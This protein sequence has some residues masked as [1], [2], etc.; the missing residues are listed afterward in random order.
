M[1]VAGA[2]AAPSWRT[3]ASLPS[4]VPSLSVARR[5]DLIMERPARERFPARAPRRGTVA[6]SSGGAG[7]IGLA[8]RGTVCCIGV[9]HASG[10]QPS[11]LPQAA[12]GR[13]VR[14]LIRCVPRQD[15][16]AVRAPR[17]AHFAR[18]VACGFPRLQLGRA[19][20]GCAAKPGLLGVQ[21][22]ASR[23]PIARARLPGGHQGPS[24]AARASL[25]LGRDGTAIE[26]SGWDGRMTRFSRPGSRVLHERFPAGPRPG[27]PRRG[28][29]RASCAGVRPHRARTARLSEAYPRDG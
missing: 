6:T 2:S 26:L 8:P 4:R 9:G 11:Q 16:R 13:W 27:S 21:G 23:R 1:P 3:T 18:E 28:W 14:R 20:S 10:G 5:M 24:Q 19:G 29:R 12:S 22:S 15:R 7:P 17:V 25:R